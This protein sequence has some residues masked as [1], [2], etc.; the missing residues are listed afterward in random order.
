MT[1]FDIV[2]SVLLALGIWQ[3]T[4]WL[5]IAPIMNYFTQQQRAK[6]AMELADL[7]EKSYKDLIKDKDEKEE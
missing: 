4:L 1:H 3:A 5:I 7:I 6:Q 2:I